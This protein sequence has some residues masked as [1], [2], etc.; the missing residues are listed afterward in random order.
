MI[1]YWNCNYGHLIKIWIFT[2]DFLMEY[3]LKH[4][5]NSKCWSLR[6]ISWFTLAFQ[7]CNFKIELWTPNVNSSWRFLTD[8]LWSFFSWTIYITKFFYHQKAIGTSKNIFF[9]NFILLVKVLTGVEM[10]RNRFVEF[11]EIRALISS[12]DSHI[13]SISIRAQVYSDLFEC[14]RKINCTRFVL[15]FARLLLPEFE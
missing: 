14:Y 5:W 1:S 2:K 13:L 6:Q 8:I 3:I 9:E 15:L 10:A 4:C 12:K 7:T 11:E